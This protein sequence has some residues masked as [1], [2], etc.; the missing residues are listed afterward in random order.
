MDLKIQLQQLFE[1][2]ESD[3]GDYAWM[4]ED[5]R[6][7]ELVFCLLNQYNPENTSD[8]RAAVSTLQYLGL[9]ET[10]K[11]ALLEQPGNENAVVLT[12]ILK[13]HGFSE[14]NAREAVTLLAHVAG[15]IRKDFGGKIQRYLRRQGEI[16]RDELINALGGKS[17]NKE[18]LRYAVSHWL[19]NA[20]SLPISLEHPAVIRFC[21]KNGV[22]LEKLL[23][24]ADDLNLNIALVD[25]L[26]ELDQK[27]KDAAPEDEAPEGG[28]K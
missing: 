28:A 5:E 15:V 7:A 25:D 21:K 18:Q 9:I 2:H 12:H 3:I 10:E 4:Y 8:V 17:L 24:T 16:M 20:L 11:L 26:L 23:H 19:Q 1:R 6:W 13:Q 27:A 14:K 22:G